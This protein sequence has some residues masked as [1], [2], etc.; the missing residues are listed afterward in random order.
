MLKTDS[1]T[2]YTH[3]SERRPPRII[4]LREIPG[5]SPVHRL[6][7]GTK[8]V[9]VAG[10][11]VVLSYYPSWGALGLAAC[12][13]LTAGLTARIPKGA[14]PRPPFWFWIII[15]ITGVLASVSGG[16]P[17]LT[18]GGVLLGLG[19]IDAYLRFV[20]IGILLLL[21]AA[22]VGWTTSL[23]EIAPAVARLM[24]P[25]RLVRFPV[26]EFAVAVALCVRSLPLLVGELRVLLAARKLRPPAPPRP[27]RARLERWLDEL[28]DVLVAALAVSVR[29]AGELSEAITARGGTGLIAANTVR[30]GRRDLLAISLVAAVCAG[31][32]LI[33]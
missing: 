27:G 4:L 25:L 29:R 21:G 15:L 18:V 9:A 16:S 6:W 12:L 2:P 17:H 1:H 10:L 22:M 13:L 20:S 26:D 8:L 11:S 23:G 3:D 32:A 14:L 33:P 7:A 19:G 30:P 24:S 5:D 28:I 31:A